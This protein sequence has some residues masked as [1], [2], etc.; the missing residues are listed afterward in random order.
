[1]IQYTSARPEI[2]EARVKLKKKHELLPRKTR[3]LGLRIAAATSTDFTTNLGKFAVRQALVGRAVEQPVRG[4]SKDAASCQ[5]QSGQKE[6]GPII[7]EVSVRGERA[8]GH[9]R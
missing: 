8:G 6:R 1:M 7:R 4:E 5:S 9:I 3:V 2:Q